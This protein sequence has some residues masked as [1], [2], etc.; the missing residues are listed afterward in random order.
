M[1]RLSSLLYRVADA[2]DS[3]VCDD[4]ELLRRY[5]ALGDEQAFRLL[6]DRHGPLVWGV[7]RRLLRRTED[8]E[9]A[10]QATFIALA[11]K[12]MMASS[13]GILPAWLHEVSRRI[14]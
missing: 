2:L 14:A 5:A 4:I 11:R 3:G 13:I 6:V 9:D 10:F 12:A 1:R 7:C 8:A